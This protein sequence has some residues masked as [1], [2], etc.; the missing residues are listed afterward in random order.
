MGELHAAGQS[1]P[2]GRHDLHAGRRSPGRHQALAHRQRLPAVHHQRPD[3][4]RPR[5][6]LAAGSGHAGD[7]ADEQA[8]LRELRGQAHSGQAGGGGDGL[9][10]P[11]HGRG[12]DPGARPGHDLCARS[13]G[14]LITHPETRGSFAFTHQSGREVWGFLILFKVKPKEENLAYLKLNLRLT[15]KFDTYALK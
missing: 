6:E 15:P 7:A 5:A 9:R 10:E 4:E 3:R 14:D 8:L 13:G 12:Y 2:L 11:A 1:H